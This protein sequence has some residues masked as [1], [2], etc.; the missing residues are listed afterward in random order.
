MTRT[1]LTYIPIVSS[2]S[3][4]QNILLPTG[5]KGPKRAFFAVYK[6]CSKTRMDKNQ[7]KTPTREGKIRQQKSRLLKS[8]FL[9]GRARSS[10]CGCI[11]ERVRRGPCLSGK[12]QGILPILGEFCGLWRH[13]SIKCFVGE[14]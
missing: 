3:E 8:G 9:N 11:L 6:Y 10:D 5:E 1:N 7:T 12:K 2:N 14:V 4:W 13:I